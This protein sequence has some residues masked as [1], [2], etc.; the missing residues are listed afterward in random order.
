MCKMSWHCHLH[1]FIAKRN[2]SVGGVFSHWYPGSG[3]ELDCIDSRSLHPYLLRLG[4]EELLVQ[5]MPESLY[6]VLEQDT[7]ITA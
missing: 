3:V 5:G 6:C 1:T 4:I 2:G 7:L